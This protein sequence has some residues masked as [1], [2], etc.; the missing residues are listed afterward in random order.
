M[1][2]RTVCVGG[3]VTDVSMI[4]AQFVQ[5]ACEF[6]SNVMIE[7]DH[8]KYINGKSLMGML[9]LNVHEGMQLHIMSD[10]ADEQQAVETLGS[11][12]GEI[13]A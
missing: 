13:S 5:K 8:K 1:T 12:F 3:K 7:I 4:S 10:G 2:T 11:L 9:S 6:K